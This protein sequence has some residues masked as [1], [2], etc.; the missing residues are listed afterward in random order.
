ME[1]FKNYYKFPLKMDDDFTIKV[2]TQDNRMAF[3]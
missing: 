2:F 1:D 3:D